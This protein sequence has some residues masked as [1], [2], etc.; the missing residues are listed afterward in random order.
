MSKKKPLERTGW[1]RYRIYGRGGSGADKDHWIY[2][3]GYDDPEQEEDTREYIVHNHESWAIH[4]EVYHLDWFYG[5]L[6]PPER[7]KAAIKGKRLSRK[8]LLE[9]MKLLKAQLAHA[10]KPAL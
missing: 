9:E 1:V 7:I 8:Y 10:P 2:I 5:E 3:P 4:A 6:P